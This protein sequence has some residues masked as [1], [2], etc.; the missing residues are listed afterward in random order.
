MSDVSTSATPSTAAGDEDDFFSSWDKPAAKPAASTPAA[1]VPVLGRA[2]SATAAPRTI[3]S[4]SL[5]SSTTSPGSRPTSKLGASRLNSSPATSTVS[6]P[7]ASSTAA[8]KSKLGGLGA[9]KAAAPIDFEQAQKRAEEE[10][11]RIRQLGYDRERERQEEEER[12]KKQAESAKTAAAARSLTPA[13]GKTT[14]APVQT[15]PLGNAQDM[16]RLGMGM[17]RLGFGAVPAAPAKARCVPFTCSH[18][19]TYLVYHVVPRLSTMLRRQHVTSLGVRRLFR[20]ICTL[21]VARTIRSHRARRKPGCSRSPVLRRSRRTSTSGVRRTKC[22]VGP[23]VTASSAT[24]RCQ[25]WKSQLKMRS[26]VCSR[27]RMCKMLRSRFVRV[28]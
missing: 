6:T 9:K 8:K 21:V 25:I 23:L 28:L 22:L 27:T 16:E 5:R 19:L 24:A 17:K 26:L 12:Q 4:S 3:S 11:E 14:T 15:K 13:S 7:T 2:A 18:L 20:P 10:A 1:S